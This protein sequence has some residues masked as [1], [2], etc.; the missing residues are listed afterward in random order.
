MTYWKTDSWRTKAFS[1]N[2]NENLIVVGDGKEI[3]TM[4][5]TNGRALAGTLTQ[6]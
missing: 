2:E 6:Q 1:W 5:V 3:E 4:I